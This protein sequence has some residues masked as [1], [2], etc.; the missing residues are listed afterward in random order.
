MEKLLKIEQVAELLQIS[1]RTAYDCVHIDFIPCYK[2]PKGVRF[3]YS[4]L[5]IWLKRRREKGR[6]KFKLNV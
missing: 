1:K 2:F 5:Q 4:E 6:L 3:R